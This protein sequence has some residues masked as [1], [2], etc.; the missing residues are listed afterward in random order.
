MRLIYNNPKKIYLFW[1]KQIFLYLCDVINQ[2]DNMG[3]NIDR[4]LEGRE[5]RQR[6]Y[7]SN[8]KSGSS[9]VIEDTKKKLLKNFGK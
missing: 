3:R 6:G 5:E 8:R 7:D 1:K 4:G 9:K 2:K